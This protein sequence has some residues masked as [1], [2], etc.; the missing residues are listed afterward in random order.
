[1]A[2]KAKFKGLSNIFGKTP[3]ARVGI[4]RYINRFRSLLVMSGV[5]AK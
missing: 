3:K 1:M 4:S 2:F 5:K